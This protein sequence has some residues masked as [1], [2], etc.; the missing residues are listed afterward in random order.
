MDT[1]HAS[2][3]ETDETNHLETNHLDRT[4]TGRLVTMWL[5]ARFRHAVFKGVLAAGLLALL[6]TA[7]GIG[8]LKAQSFSCR[9]VHHPDERAICHDPL[10]SRL[11]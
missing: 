8:Q 11:D 10:L 2:V 5:A 3:I 7:Y 4:R 9:Y 6:I 1:V